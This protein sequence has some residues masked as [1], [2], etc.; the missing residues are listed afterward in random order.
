MHSAAVRAPSGVVCHV[1]PAHAH[2]ARVRLVLWA[3]PV[4][5]YGCVTDFAQPV[6]LHCCVYG[7]EY[8]Y[9][10]GSLELDRDRVN[11]VI[12][13]EVPCTARRELQQGRARKC[14]ASWHDCSQWVVGSAPVG[15]GEVSLVSL[16]L[17]T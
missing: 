7:G 10:R 17:P 13:Y 1:V 15:C 12:R 11:S 5:G 3:R 4:E 2:V 8:M 6:V 14:I 9:T 16:T